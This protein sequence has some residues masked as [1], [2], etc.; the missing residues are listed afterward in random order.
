[1]SRI[2]TVNDKSNIQKIW[3]R[4]FKSTHPYSIPFQPKIEACLFFPFTYGAVLTSTQYRAVIKTAQSLGE[5]NFLL[6]ETEIKDFWDWEGHW[7]CQF[8][9]HHEY[10][11]LLDNRGGLENTMYSSDSHWG[12]ITAHEWHA[13]VGGS[14][15]FVRNVDKLYPAWRSEVIEYIDEWEDQMKRGMWRG[16]LLLEL[17]EYWKTYPADEWV[18]TVTAKLSRKLEYRVA[19]FSVD[20]I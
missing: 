7:R 18:E 19:P 12:V 6:S 13:L 1:M 20:F 14:I 17:L 11:E 8:P 2:E 15:D 5:V 3:E 9:T 16:A 4:I 10:S